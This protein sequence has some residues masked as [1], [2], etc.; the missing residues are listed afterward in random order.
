MATGTVKWFNPTKGFGFIEPDD[1]GADTFV[2]ISAVEQAGFSTLHDGQKVS[3]ELEADRRT[4]KQSAVALEVLSDGDPAPRAPRPPRDSF[5]PS[6]GGGGGGGG[7]GGGDRV[8][9][10][11][12]QGVVKWFNRTKGFGFIIPDGGGEE[13]FVHNSAVEQSGLRGLSDGQQVAFD[14]ELDRRKN[15]TSAVNLRVLGDG[16][17]GSSRG[18]APRRW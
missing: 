2:H 7:F 13:I 9:Q 3:F 16:D 15:K 18:P 8:S 6:G 17:G 10:G 14:I 4:G 5:R 11:A 12:G 1:G